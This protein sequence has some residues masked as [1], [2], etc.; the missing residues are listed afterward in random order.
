[1][2]GLI[3]TG[4]ANTIDGDS[5]VDPGQV[6]AYQSDVSVAAEQ[7]RIAEA[8]R[9]AEA[10][11]AVT[12][13][14]CS[15]F[16][17]T[18]VTMLN[19]YNQFVTKLNEVQSYSGTEGG[20]KVVIDQLTAGEQAI[21]A[22]LVPGIEQSVDSLVREFLARNKELMDAVRGEMRS[23]LNEPADRWIDAR[24]KAVEACGE[25]AR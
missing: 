14:L 8:S 25:I 21:S 11:R 15:Q 17:T 18:V 23:G 1:M 16:T 2:F 12:L 6:S 22:K 4:C 13:D 10:A 24:N 9:E 7:S 3:F 19:S 5:T 20:G